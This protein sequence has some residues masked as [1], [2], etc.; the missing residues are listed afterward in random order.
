MIGKHAP[1]AEIAVVRQGE[2]FAAGLLLH[3]GHPF[4]EIARIIAA[5]RRINGEWFDQA[6][7]VAVFAKD[8]VAMEVVAAGVRGPLE[9]DEGRE[10]A[11]VVGIV[12]CLD[13]FAPGAAVR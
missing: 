12:R 8:D 9:A 13:R 6:R 10:A 11:R 2:H 7:A 1:V 4:P 5:E 3:S